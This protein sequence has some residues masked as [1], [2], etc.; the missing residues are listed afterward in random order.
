MVGAELGPLDT[1]KR[2]L[3]PSTGVAVV[4]GI[5]GAFNVI[6]GGRRLPPA[7]GACRVGTGTGS[8]SVVAGE[9]GGLG[10]ASWS[11]LKLRF[12][13]MGVVIAGR[14]EKEKRVFPV[15]RRGDDGKRRAQRVTS[16]TE[17]V[18]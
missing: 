17:L 5:L 9:T 8:D 3:S 15:G 14:E 12:L 11:D 6:G 10:V 2:V 18:S 1:V 16:V 7:T 4:A 13:R